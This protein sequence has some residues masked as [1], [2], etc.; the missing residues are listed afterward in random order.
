M[1][2]E[3][4]MFIKK[5]V[6]S[7]KNKFVSRKENI[8]AL[9]TMLK[10]G[11]TSGNIAMLDSLIEEYDAQIKYVMLQRNALKKTIKP[12]KETK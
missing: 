6:G 3:L 12:I 4:G 7:R 10:D 11:M 8:A 1:R 2:D 9:V 5:P